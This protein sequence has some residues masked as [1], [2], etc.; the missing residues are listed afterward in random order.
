MLTARVTKVHEAQVQPF[1]QVRDQ[2][3]SLYVER[4]SAKLARQAGEAAL[5]RWQADASSIDT[6]QDL[7]VSRQHLQGLSPAD[8]EHILAVPQAELPS[9]KGFEQT[10][11]GYLL[12]RIKEIAPLLDESQPADARQTM[13]EGMRLQVAQSLSHAEVEAYYEVLKQAYDVQIRVPRPN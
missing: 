13:L 12:A 8:V 9:L 2:V 3:Q 10:D 11:G 7:T 5:A 6:E 4:E 1:E